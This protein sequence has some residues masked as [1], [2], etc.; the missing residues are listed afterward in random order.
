MRSREEVGW[1]S[2]KVFCRGR[3]GRGEKGEGT[4]GAQEE[5]VRERQDEDDMNDLERERESDGRMGWSE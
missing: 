4:E 1:H 5:D 3:A 2:T